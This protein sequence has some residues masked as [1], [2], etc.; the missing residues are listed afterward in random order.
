MGV[1]SR[2]SF[3][4]SQSCEDLGCEFGKLYQLDS[5]FICI[6]KHERNFRELFHKSNCV[7]I[8]YSVNK[9]VVEFAFTVKDE[10]ESNFVLI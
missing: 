1:L 9:Q 4:L 6:L 7:G 8:K 10:V 3:S 5:L 2:P